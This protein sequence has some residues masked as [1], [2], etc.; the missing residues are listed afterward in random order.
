MRFDEFGR[1]LSPHVAPATSPAAAEWITARLLPVEPHATRVGSV[2]PTGFE[3]YARILH[4]AT[5]R[6][7]ED[8]LISWHVAARAAGVKIHAETQWESIV[9]AFETGGIARPWTQD[10]MPGRCPKSVLGALSA[11]LADYTSTSDT[12]WYAMWTGFPGVESLAKVAARFELPAREYALLV[13][14]ISAA[15]DV[16]EGRSA[17]TPTASLWW[18]DD[19]SW[20]VA[21]EVDFRWTY[22]GGSAACIR[23]VEANSTLEVLRTA[24]E[25]RGD[26]ESD[27]TPPVS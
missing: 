18:P 3:E 8:D 19:R 13:G 23:D 14:P 1:R 16:I 17:L 4:P 20:C 9:E 26:I 2:V 12:V 22:V 21:T 24:P 27:W 7:P 11:V 6:K 25:H 10:P 15:S 5:G